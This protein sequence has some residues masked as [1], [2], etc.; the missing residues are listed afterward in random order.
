VVFVM[1][2]GPVYSVLA[3]DGDEPS[4]V[5]KIEPPGKVVD[6]ETVERSPRTTD[7]NKVSPSACIR[8]APNGETRRKAP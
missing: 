4:S 6:M 3:N 1:V 5:Q 2:N 7:S 8:G